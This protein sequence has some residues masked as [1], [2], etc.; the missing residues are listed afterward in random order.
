MGVNEI[1]QLY[2]D[3]ID[4]GSSYIHKLP[5]GRTMQLPFQ[6]TYIQLQISESGVN[7]IPCSIFCTC[8]YVFRF[9]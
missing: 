5:Y 2:I 4:R 1:E 7:I 6:D 8:Y 3:M 9:V